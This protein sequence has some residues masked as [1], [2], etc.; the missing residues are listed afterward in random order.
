MTAELQAGIVAATAM[1]YLRVLVVSSLFNFALGRVLALP[2]L[3]LAAA[4]G[5]IAWQRARFASASANPTSFSNPLQLS[6]A[7]V[8]AFLFVATSMLATYVERHLGRGGIFALAGVVG[9][10]DIDPFVLSLAQGVAGVSVTTAASAI[11]IAASS[12]NLLKAVY[13]MA[14]ARRREA[15]VPAAILGSLAALGVVIAL[16]VFR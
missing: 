3:A 2:L 6:T 5:S 4:S 11:L 13:T 16:T 14:F 7:L 15:A 8:F 12:N 10:S 9:V 1:M